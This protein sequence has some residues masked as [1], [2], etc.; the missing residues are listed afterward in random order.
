MEMLYYLASISTFKTQL[1][2]IPPFSRQSCLWLGQTF[3]LESVCL[4][5]GGKG[6]SQSLVKHLRFQ[7]RIGNFV[8]ARLSCT[9]TYCSPHSSDY[10]HELLSISETTT[11]LVGRKVRLHVSNSLVWK[12]VFGYKWVPANP[13]GM[14]F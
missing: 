12:M 1:R 4:L 5:F 8:M 13:F 7:T 6:Y 2:L 10:V 3:C 14:G 11:N 9:I